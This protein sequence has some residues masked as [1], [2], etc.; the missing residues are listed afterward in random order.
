[1]VFQGLSAIEDALI[2][3]VEKAVTDL[4]G[5]GIK[6]WMATGDKFDTAYNIANSRS[7]LAVGDG[8]NDCT[9]L[10]QANVGVGI[11]GNEGLQA[12]SRRMID[13]NLLRVHKGGDCEL[14]KASE[15]RRGRSGSL[16][17]EIVALDNAWVKAQFEVDNA[18]QKFNALN[19]M[20]ATKKK[21]KQSCEEEVQQAIALKAA[22]ASEEVRCSE[23]RAQ[24]DQK[25][26]RVGNVLHASV[27]TSNDE[28]DNKLMVL[29]GEPRVKQITHQPGGYA[30]YELLERLGGVETAKAAAIAGHRAY[31]LTGYGAMLNQALFQ[32]A[33]SFLR[34]H[35]YTSVQTPFFMRKSFMT[36]AAEL[37]DFEETLYR[38]PMS[39]ERDEE[40][41]YLIATSEQPLCCLHA[42]QS[43]RNSELPIKYCGMSTC[44]R[45]EA[46]AHGKDMKGIFRVHQFEK[47]EQFVLCE[48]EQSWEM[49]ESMI[50]LSASFYE[51]LNIPYRVVSIVS[52]A[53]NNAAAKKYD[54]EAWFPS[55]E[56]F[57]ELVSCSNCTDYQ[58]RALNIKLEQKAFTCLDKQF[59]HL[60]NGTLCAT[61]RSMCCLLENWQTETGVE[62]PLPLQP[63]MDGLTFMPFA[64]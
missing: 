41:L 30:H 12:Y 5:A 1:M 57:R 33:A 16:I 36:K 11:L 10:I 47:V 50:R 34:R 26:A 14:V 63:Y 54:L 21:Q 59:V 48:P 28:A 17:D 8:A 7:V 29:S 31:Y 6:I 13:I 3:G 45:K 32:Y 46:G 55:H 40:D 27:P 22:L 2:D 52:G 15:V 19:K 58:S 23:L 51:S 62:V 20:I 42:D 60:L 9:M 35:G 25:L 43:F 39:E 49:L 53:L 24:R 44:F 64:Q 61:E 37:E 4:L 18:R 56:D 38:I